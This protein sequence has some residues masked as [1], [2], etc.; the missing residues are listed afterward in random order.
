[1]DNREV[2]LEAK[3]L[4]FGYRDGEMALS[5]VS[6]SLRRGE[7]VALLGHNGSGKSTLA[8]LLMGLLVPKCG[9]IS[10]F[11]EPIDE[12]HLSSLRRRMGIVFQNPD[13]QFVASSVEEDI[14]FGLENLSVPRQEMK[15]RVKAAAEAVGMEAFLGKAPENLSGGQKQRV[16]LAGAMAMEP[17][18]LILDEAT[19]MLDPRGK[20]E[21]YSALRNMRK[22]HSSLSLIS[23]THDVEEAL[24]SDKV[25]VLSE[26][27]IALEGTPDEVFSNAGVLK[28]LRL[29]PPFGYRLASALKRYGIGLKPGKD[30]ESSLEGLW[31]K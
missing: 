29:Y 30:L 13:N 27:K 20:R 23:I 26:G 16:A 31:R 11:G 28:D 8:K 14:A 3:G 7:Y 15:E 21:V 4:G 6:F 22:L 19:S 2:V 10:V 18:I 12:A 24:L 9:G 17:E 5:D 1:M 25:I